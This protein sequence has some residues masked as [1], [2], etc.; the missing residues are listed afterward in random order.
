MS[1]FDLSQFELSDTAV[2]NVENPKGDPL[3]AD[4]KQVTITLY[5]T[6]S[7]QYVNAKYK[8]DNAT[9]TRSMALIRGKPVHN[10]AEEN[11]KLR[12][13]FLA[14]CT[15]SIDGL[16]VQAIEIYSNPKLGYITDQ[17]DKFLGESENF[18]PVLPQS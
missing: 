2:L 4:G 10:A 9:Q 18:M 15:A 3:L 12:A 1:K 13:E 17:V 16:P 14:A 6:G 8:L 11:T 7:K 5:G